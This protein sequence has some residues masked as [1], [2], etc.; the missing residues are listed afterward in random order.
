MMTDP[1]ADMLTRIRNAQRAGRPHVLIPFSNVKAHIVEILRGEGYVASVEKIT[2]AGCPVLQVQLKYDG[3]Q[4]F[5]QVLKRESKPGH[6]VYC[7]AEELPHVLNGYGVSI[8][9]TSQGIMTNKE[10]RKRGV[11]GE[12]ICSVY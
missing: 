3:K 4:P 1:I 5:I 12:I 6:R 8:V 9:P 11:G 7:K 10:A 2:D